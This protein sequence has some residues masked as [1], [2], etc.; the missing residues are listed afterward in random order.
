[1]DWDEPIALTGTIKAETD[2][3]ILFVEE[4]CTEAIWFPRSQIESDDELIAGAEVSIEIP[5][6]L[7][8]DKGLA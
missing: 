7:A 4:G 2:L 8:A 5:A 1:M 3:A 6:W